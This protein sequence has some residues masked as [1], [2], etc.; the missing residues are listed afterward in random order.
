MGST[1]CLNRMRRMLE[2]SMILGLVL[3]FTAPGWSR[4]ESPAGTGQSRPDRVVPTGSVKISGNHQFP[5][6]L[7]GD[8]GKVSVSHSR[9]DASYSRYTLSWQTSWYSWQD[10][11]ALPFG[12]ARTDPWNDLHSLSLLVDQRGRLSSR[13]SYFVQGA[14]RSGFEKQI[15]RSLGI[16]ANG[17]VIYG[18]DEDWSLGLGGYIGL[19]PTSRFGFSS[20]FAMVG[21]F[22]QYRHPGATGF[23]ARLGFPQSE[24]RYTFNPVWSTWLGVGINSGTYRLADN[25]TVMP[26]GYVRAKTYTSGIYLD[27]TPTPSLTIRFGPTYNFGRRLDFYDSGGD[28]R[29]G[30]DLKAVPGLE[31]GVNWTF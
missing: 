27:V 14:I 15:S 4:E 1:I 8:Q 7:N 5:G 12:D 3:L 11:H 17:G 9:V 24:L 19:A 23:S 29:R 16:A 30:Y 2:I 31:A 25:N 22:V 28:K 20:T 26:R 6:H 21:P 13:W 10:K 18:W